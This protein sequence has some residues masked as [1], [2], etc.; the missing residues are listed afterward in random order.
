MGS[1][2]KSGTLMEQTYSEE[3]YI[4]HFYAVLPAF[5]DKRYIR[6]DGKP[7]FVVFDPYGLPD[8]Y[9]FYW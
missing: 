1:L 4:R 2:V 7:L 9:L 5:K 3:D 8:A 6:V